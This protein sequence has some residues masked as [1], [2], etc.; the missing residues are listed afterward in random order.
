MTSQDT[1]EPAT[2]RHDDNAEKS[3]ASWGYVFNVD[4]AQEG[5]LQRVSFEDMKSNIL[6]KTDGLAQFEGTNVLSEDLVTRRSDLSEAPWFFLLILAVLV[7]EQ[8]LAVHLSF[9]LKG[10]EGVAHVGQRHAA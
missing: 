5:P 6:D 10:N 1:M 7:A 4:T 3:L 9:H 8:A 2:L